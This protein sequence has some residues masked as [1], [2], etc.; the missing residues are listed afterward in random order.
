[1]WVDC[2]NYYCTHPEIGWTMSCKLLMGRE[3]R[4]VLQFNK[5]ITVLKVHRK[6]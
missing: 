6:K 5:H 3:R 2:I 1:M 4:W